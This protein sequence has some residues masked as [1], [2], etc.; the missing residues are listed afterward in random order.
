MPLAKV[1]EPAKSALTPSAVKTAPLPVYWFDFLPIKPNFLSGSGIVFAALFGL[2]ASTLAAMSVLTAISAFCRRHKK[3]REFF[4]RIASICRA[5]PLNPDRHH[6]KCLEDALYLVIS[7]SFPQLSKHPTLKEMR[8]CTRD[9][10]NLWLDLD[11]K[12][13]EDILLAFG[14][15]ESVYAPGFEFKPK[16]MSDFSSSVSRLRVRFEKEI[17][18]SIR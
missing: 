8:E 14:F 15:V 10:K 5:A 17:K 11:E 1:L 7:S 6:A 13:R 9:G 4:R 16:E 3:E 12:A 2:A 18:G